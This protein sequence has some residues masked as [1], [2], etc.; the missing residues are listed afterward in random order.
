MCRHTM[1]TLS[2][3]MVPMCGTS[4]RSWA[5][6]PLRTTARYT[7][8]VIDELKAV[9]QRAHPAE[10]VGAVRRFLSVADGGERPM[11]SP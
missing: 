6:P 3:R 4:R 8:V 5:R 10:R 11:T 2:S 1:A 9:H 7:H